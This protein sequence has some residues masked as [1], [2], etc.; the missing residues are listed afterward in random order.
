MEKCPL[1]LSDAQLSAFSKIHRL[2]EI[3]CH[4]AWRGEAEK[5]AKIAWW[6]SALGDIAS[7]PQAT[8]RLNI[9]W[10]S[11]AFNLGVALFDSVL[12]KAADQTSMLLSRVLDPVHLQARMN[13][14]SSSDKQLTC[15][16]PRLSLIVQ[17]FDTVLSSVG[18]RLNSAPHRLNQLWKMLEAMY[19]SELG[20]SRDRFA[21][22]TQPVMFIGGLANDPRDSKAYIFFKLLALFIHFWDDWMDMAEDLRNPAP[23]AFLTGPKS[24]APFLALTNSLHGLFRILGG[25][26]YHES[27]ARTLSDAIR[28]TLQAAKNW[29]IQ[30]HRK[31]L[32][33]CHELIL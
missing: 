3:A 9:M 13:H 27:I 24:T 31:T 28:D 10:E 30:A 11:A 5:L 15:Q 16:E 12:E 14:P 1:G 23:N 19:R 29:D 17:L 2:P 8:D 18:G 26:L 33:L 21:A 25:A 20:L 6:G 4:F 7:T 22:K 32:A